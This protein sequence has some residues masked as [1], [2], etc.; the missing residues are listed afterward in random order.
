MSDKKFP[1]ESCRERLARKYGEDAVALSGPCKGIPVADCVCTQLENRFEDVSRRFAGDERKVKKLAMKLAES[2]MRDEDDTGECINALARVGYEKEAASGIADY[3]RSYA[4]ETTMSAEMEE[5]MD[6]VESEEIVDDDPVVDEGLGDVVDDIEE[7]VVNKDDE[8]MDEVDP[9]EDIEP[10]EPIEEVGEVLDDTVSI[11]VPVE[12]AEEVRNLLDEQLD[13]GEQGESDIGL[14]DEADLDLPGEVVIETVDE[15]PGEPMDM[16]EPGKQIIEGD[17]SMIEMGEETGVDEVEEYECAKCGSEGRG[18]DD[19]TGDVPGEHE[20]PGEDQR[21][22]DPADKSVEKPDKDDD[23]IPDWADKKPKDKAETEEEKDEQRKESSMKREVR[24]AYSEFGSGGESAQGGSNKK[25]EDPKAIA[26]GNLETEGYTANDHNFTGESTM[27][28]EKKFDAKKVDPSEVSGGSA[29]LQGQDESFPE[30]KPSVPAGSAPIGNEELT[31]GD[32]ATKGTV[33]ATVTPNGIVIQTPEGKKFLAKASISKDQLSDKLVEAIKAIEYDGNGR[34]FAKSALKVFKKH[35]AKAN[36]PDVVATITPQ[37]IVFKTPEGKAYLAKVAISEPSDK[38]VEAIKAI[39]WEGNVQKFAAASV[40]A[41]KQAQA[42]GDSEKQPETDTSEK[43]AK[44]FT[45]DEGPMEP[46]DQ[47]TVDKAKPTPKDEGVV[48]TDT[49]KL[50]AEEFT[51]DGEKKPEAG[52]EASHK[53]ETKEA[54]DRKLPEAKPISEGNLETDGYTANDHNFQD[55]STMGAEKKFDAEKPSNTSAGSASLMG[56]DE[57][58]PEGRPSI[59]VGEADTNTSIKG[60]VIADAENEAKLREARLKS[61]SVYVADLL[62][63]G[64]IADNEYAET[65]EKTA[66]MSV[67]A[68]QQLALSTKKARERMASRMKDVAP[69]RPEEQPG[70]HLPVVISSNEK[71]SLQERLVGA[72]KLT[73]DLDALEKGK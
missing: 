14:S 48:K 50:E 22:D 38:L 10:L 1:I 19:E 69:I 26:D 12:I 52:K 54:A 28:A 53:K 61:A 8:A 34:A 33:I 11:E 62:R 25:I 13:G 60:T 66:A 43:E 70:L 36:K 15:I 32:L 4:M 44:E 35:A 65:L 57:S 24:V 67:P 42:S 2:F 49:S 21:D 59:P 51:N 47:A 64:D 58:L 17:D 55:H 56:Q 68:I 23:N 6:E 40:K 41:V 27:G 31:G 16:Q 18:R 71:Q 73:R 3:I 7:E 72:F 63:N 46:E 29:S 20:E 39:D 37:G 9:T 5:L 45:N 30:G